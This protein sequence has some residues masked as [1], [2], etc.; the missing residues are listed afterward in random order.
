MVILA[1]AT[2][3]PHLLLLGYIQILIPAGTK[4]VILPSHMEES[5]CTSR[6]LLGIAIN[7]FLCVAFLA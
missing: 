4:W 7:L 6:F 2:Y 1:I 5:Y 3:Q